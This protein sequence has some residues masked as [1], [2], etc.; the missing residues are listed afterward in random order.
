MT[1][2]EKWKCIQCVSICFTSLT[3]IKLTNKN[4]N[5]DNSEVFPHCIFKMKCFSRSKTH[6]RKCQILIY[7]KLNCVIKHFAIKISYAIIVIV[8]LYLCY[9]NNLHVNW[10]LSISVNCNKF[11]KL[12]LMSMQ[13][14]Y[15]YFL[16]I[17]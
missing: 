7:R 9:S 15:K 12:K 5:S 11:N 13:S 17:Y 2:H 16:L 8:S 10:P 14:K 6:W 1:E 4:K 3:L